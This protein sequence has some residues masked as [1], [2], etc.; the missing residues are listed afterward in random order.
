M[1]LF[2]YFCNWQKYRV[3]NFKDLSKKSLVLWTLSSAH[4]KNFGLLSLPIS[5]DKHFWAKFVLI[6]NPKN[7][8]GWSIANIME[9]NAVDLKNKALPK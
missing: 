4:F 9:I 5:K 8:F 7:A 2:D 6:Y 1:K 3:A